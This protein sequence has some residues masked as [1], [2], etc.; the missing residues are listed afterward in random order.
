MTKAKRA[1][2]RLRQAKPVANEEFHMSRSLS[3]DLIPH[4]GTVGY[5]SEITE[6]GTEHE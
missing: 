1:A 4:L 5:P 2:F 6:T 3:S